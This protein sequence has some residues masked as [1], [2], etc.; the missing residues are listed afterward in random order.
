MH[1]TYTYEHLLYAG[2]AIAE[3]SSALIRLTKQDERMI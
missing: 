1:V 3:A 2:K